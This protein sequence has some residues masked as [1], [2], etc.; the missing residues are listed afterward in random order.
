MATNKKLWIALGSALAIGLGAYIYIR[1]RNAA[2]EE[3]SGDVSSAEKD[4]T[5]TAKDKSTNTVLAST[6]FKSNEEGNKFR[7]WVNDMYP[8]WAKA[9]QLD[10]TGSFDNSFIRS[11]WKLYGEQYLKSNQPRTS[12]PVSSGFKPNDDVFISPKAKAVAIFSF[13]SGEKNEKG[14]FKYMLAGLSRESFL[15][16]PIGKFVTDINPNWIKMQGVLK[17]QKTD[18]YVQ[19][20][21]VSKSPFEKK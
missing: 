5:S 1:R 3:Y 16:K 14:G 12:A 19:S 21:L 11:A 9:N 8:D 13:P 7:G 6:P 18:V 2:I 20:G 4:A 17:G 15:D 10:R